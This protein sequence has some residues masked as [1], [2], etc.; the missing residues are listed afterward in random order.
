[1]GEVAIKNGDWVK[2]ETLDGP[3]QVVAVFMGLVKVKRRQKFYF[4]KE[5]EVKKV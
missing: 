1:M 3:A 4:F 2:A 5:F